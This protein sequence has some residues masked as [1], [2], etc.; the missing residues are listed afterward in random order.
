VQRGEIC[1]RG[2]LESRHPALQEC[3]NSKEQ[4]LLLACLTL[5]TKTLFLR[6]AAN[7]SPNNTASQ[8]CRLE[9]ILYEI[10]L[11]EN[12]KIPSVGCDGVQ[13]DGCDV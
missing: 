8:S 1:V 6:N 12:L 4:L 3:C 2:N 11:A 13:F 10:L 9:H 5:K 7:Y